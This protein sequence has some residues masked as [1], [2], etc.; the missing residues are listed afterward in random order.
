MVHVVQ[1]IIYVYTHTYTHVTVQYVSKS[2][3]SI[4]RASYKTQW[5]PSEKQVNRK[6]LQKITYTFT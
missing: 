2:L 3:F 1:S 4:Y 5:I 6:F